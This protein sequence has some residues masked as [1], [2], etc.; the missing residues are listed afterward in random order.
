MSH[1]QIKRAPSTPQPTPSSIHDP[2]FHYQIDQ[3]HSITVSSLGQVLIHTSSIPPLH[4]PSIRSARSR[5]PDARP[6]A[7]GVTDPIQHQL[8]LIEPPVALVPYSPPVARWLIHYYLRTIRKLQRHGSPLLPLDDNDTSA[9]AS[10]HTPT[11]YHLPGTRYPH[12]A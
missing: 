1:T 9:V 8:L 10:T 12:L 7:Y 3:D 5:W 4:Y 6:D 2:L 11:I